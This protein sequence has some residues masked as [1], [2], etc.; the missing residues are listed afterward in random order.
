MH[1][2]I[3]ALSLYTKQHD[4]YGYTLCNEDHDVLAIGSSNPTVILKVKNEKG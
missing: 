4:H 2:N 1:H 3:T